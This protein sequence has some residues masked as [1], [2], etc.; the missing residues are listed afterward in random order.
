M[1]K[2]SISRF[3]EKVV[4]Q[5]GGDKAEAILIIAVDGQNFTASCIGPD[6]L[7]IN[8]KSVAL[9]GAMRTLLDEKFKLANTMYSHLKQQGRI[10]TEL[11]EQVVDVA[12]EAFEAVKP[13]EQ[14]KPEWRSK[15]N[16]DPEVEF[17]HGLFDLLERTFGGGTNAHDD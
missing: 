12:S 8:D 11:Q 7:L 3:T 17:L 9:V 14:P 6:P 2:V 15:A 5:R 1:E 13:E 4:G 10:R 16:P